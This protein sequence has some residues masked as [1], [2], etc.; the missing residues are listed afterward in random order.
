MYSKPAQ[1]TLQH[2]LNIVMQGS[3][4]R[5]QQWQIS[6]FL[7]WTCHSN[8]KREGWCHEEW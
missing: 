6:P 4:K 1:K 3:L 8:T 2:I 5:L 7:G